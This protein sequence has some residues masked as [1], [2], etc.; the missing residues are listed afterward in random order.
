MLFHGRKITVNKSLFNNVCKNI[1][2]VHQYSVHLYRIFHYLVLNISVF[3][4]NTLTY[5]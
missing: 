2:Y 5:D 4:L 1:H 3:D